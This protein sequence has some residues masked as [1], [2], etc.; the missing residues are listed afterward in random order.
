MSH[1]PC[2]TQP[3]RFLQSELPL[4]PAEDCRYHLISVPY[5]DNV[6]YG[7][8]TS[9]GPA[10]ILEASDQ[11]EAWDGESIPGDDGI[12]TGPVVDCTG[13]AEAVLGRIER[14]VSAAL[15]L[16][17]CPV[18][19][20]GEHTVTLGALR[21]IARSRAGQ[22]KFG[23]VQ[24]DAHG[25]LRN[26]Y[27]DTPYS[28]GS[29]MR[30]ACDLGLP[31]MQIAVRSLCTE[32]VDFRKAY[33][34]NHLDAA[35]FSRLGGLSAIS[36]PGFKLLPDDFPPD[37]YVTFD[38][39]AL[40]ASLMPATGTPDPGGL[41]WYDALRLLELTVQGRRVIGLDLVEVA[42]MPHYHAAEFTAAKLL[43]YFFGIIQRHALR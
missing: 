5:E 19:L 43:Y 12:F 37:F 20:G 11:L 35:A 42:P 4:R 18:L 36:Q 2:L 3:R 10:A 25:D 27:E 14:A 34:V 28:H 33:G 38:I 24:F 40:D 9:L 15:T 29:V 31:L 13:S 17:N 22:P 8:G 32:E 39:D 26:T 30:R 16:G 23:V 7:G 1:S 21:A 41:S 6:S